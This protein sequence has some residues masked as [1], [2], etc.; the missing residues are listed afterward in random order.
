MCD[1]SVSLTIRICMKYPS[2][3]L[4][5]GLHVFSHGRIPIVSSKVH[6]P[7]TTLC[8]IPELRLARHCIVLSPIDSKTPTHPL[9]CLTDQYE[10]HEC[11]ARY[12][13]ND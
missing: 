9:S 8:F 7:S 2:F 5:E 13:T 6:A 10:Y 12:L 1:S 11:A 3:T 4:N